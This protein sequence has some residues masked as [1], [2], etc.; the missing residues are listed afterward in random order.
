[1]LAPLVLA[2][3]SLDADPSYAVGQA[4][5]EGLWLSAQASGGVAGD[6]VVLGLGAGVGFE[7]R[8]FAAHLRVPL[9]LRVVDLPPAVSP[10]QPAVCRVIRCEEWLEGGELSADSLSKVVDELRVLQ[11]G[12]VFHLRGGALFATLGHGVLVSRYTNAADWDRRRS[13]L[14]LQ[15]DLPWGRTRIQALTGG[16]LSPQDLFAAR[17]STSPLDDGAADDALDR[18][19]GR[20]RLGFEIAGDAAAPVRQATDDA[21]DIR[22]SAPRRPIVGGAT[23]L[24]WPLLDESAGQGGF[25]LEPFVAASM[26]TGLRHGTV[27]V[28][29]GGRVG[30]DATLDLIVFAMRAGVNL[31]VDTPWHRSS[32]F[33]TLYDVDRRRYVGVDG[34]F[35]DVG[36]AE[37]DTPGG[38]GG[39]A[40]VEVLVLRTVKLGGRFHVDPV[41]EATQAEVFGEVAAG[42]VRVA[43]RAMQRA[44]TDVASALAFGD[45]TF[46]VTEAAWSLL[47]PFSLY[48]RWLHTPRFHE[49]AGPDADDDV[50]VGASFDL[51]LSG[52]DG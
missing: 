18:F 40:L 39:G 14:Y 26:M 42:P 51:V 41:P 9:T 21:G 28:G 50:V 2:L 27:G 52:A 36:I 12:D 48:A 22:A 11:P 35:A 45:R 10:A 13:G 33:S 16:A 4:P 25:Q 43:G 8:P 17:V 44:F 46:V 29:A 32:V 47:P 31:L 38:A 19:L 49:I 1:M 30:I 5:P 20:L 7:T 3:L 23:D 6:D 24:S 37:L 15:S 34:R